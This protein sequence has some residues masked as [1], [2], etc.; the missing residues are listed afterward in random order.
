MGDIT[1]LSRIRKMVQYNLLAGL[2]ANRP[3]IVPVSIAPNVNTVTISDLLFNYQIFTVVGYTAA[4]ARIRTTALTALIASIAGGTLD[5]LNYID[6]AISQINGFGI[7]DLNYSLITSEDIVITL[8]GGHNLTS[9]VFYC[10][11]ASSL[12]APPDVQNMP[13]IKETNV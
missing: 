8:T 2:P 11:P 3:Q 7:A 5:E 6:D 10:L 12:V 9:L 13:W 1:E 4:R